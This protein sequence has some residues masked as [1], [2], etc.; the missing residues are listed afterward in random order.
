MS[1]VLNINSIRQNL[2]G[3]LAVILIVLY[4]IFALFPK[5]TNPLLS[6]DEAWYADIAR[7]ILESGNPLH[8]TFNG[9]DYYDHPPLG[10]WLM[11]LSMK[12]FG[13]TET[14]AR[15]P[16][17]IAAITTLGLLYQLGKER[18]GK[19]L[20]LIAPMMMASS[21]WF[22]YRARSGNLDSL[23]VCFFVLTVYAFGRLIE[24]PKAKRWILITGIAMGGL[25]LTKTVVGVGI[26]PVL[27][28][29]FL[30]QAKAKFKLLGSILGS[31][32]IAGIICWPWYH[33]S[34]VH[35]PNFIQY[36]F[37][38]I[39]LRS[40]Q[41]HTL[42]MANV[43]QT[44][45]YLRSG[46]GKWYYGAL[47]GVILGSIIVWLKA[48]RTKYLLIDWVWVLVIGLPFLLSP[49]T[50]VWH[51]LPVYA[52]L[53]LLVTTI[54][55]IFRQ[56]IL[57]ARYRR[58]FSLGILICCL[59]IAMKQGVAV[60]KLTQQNPGEGEKEI[61]LAARSLKVPI[62]LN[63]PFL[64]AFVYYSHQTL[65]SPLFMV[66]DS[67]HEIQTK[68]LNPE[69]PEAFVLTANDYQKVTRD[70]LPKKDFARTQDYYIILTS[71][72]QKI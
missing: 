40:N 14:A 58:A 48:L 36:H 56:K 3:L 67:Y 49:K 25:I 4:G 72:R 24:A 52:P 32:L 5:L 33:Y 8:Q 29:L 57:P 55:G 19:W 30:T 18:A 44:L 37:W 64:P 1:F 63:G 15:M 62:N 10:F 28:V 47:L 65:V 71:E 51:L 53:F 31:L 17:V 7:N 35:Y 20:G 42:T 27:L 13:I 70:H 34:I 50:E 43:L 21:L 60:A 61:G 11:S 69:K 68:L 54:V 26:A 66:P 45:L 23:L 59:G 38:G 6:Y 41:S 12:L 9:K 46:I 2:S 16:S 39:G 22:M